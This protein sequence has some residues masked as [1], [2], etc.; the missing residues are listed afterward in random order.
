MVL[1]VKWRRVWP[2]CNMQGDQTAGTFHL[3]ARRNWD[4]GESGSFEFLKKD[5]GGPGRDT[6]TGH[7]LMRR[8]ACMFHELSD[9]SHTVRKAY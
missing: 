8:H 6:A 5:T 1:L 4:R 2:K 7:R 3:K 9:A